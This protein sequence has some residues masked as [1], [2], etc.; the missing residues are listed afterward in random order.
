MK[1]K[2]VSLENIFLSKIKFNFVNFLVK[3]GPMISVS[4]FPFWTTAMEIVY[5]SI[6]FWPDKKKILCDVQYSEKKSPMEIFFGFFFVV[7]LLLEKSKEKK[8]LNILAIPSY[9]CFS[10]ILRIFS[11]F[12]SVCFDSTLVVCS[13]EPCVSLESQVIYIN[14]TFKQYD[15]LFFWIKIEKKYHIYFPNNEVFPPVDKREM[16]KRNRT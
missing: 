9:V 7:V 12:L 8:F 15:F 14:M 10:L 3:L 2:G 5:I 13:I 16:K 1:I 11:V 4:L 6:K